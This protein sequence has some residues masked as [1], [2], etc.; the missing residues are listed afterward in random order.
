[1]LEAVIVV[2]IITV[3]FAA[4]LSTAAYFLRG[5]LRAADSV[6]TAFLLEEGVEAVRFLRDNGYATYITPLVATTTT[7]YLERTSTGWR[8]SS[9]PSLV[10]NEY[11]RTIALARVYRRNSDDD[12][13]PA[14]S[15]DPKTIDTHTTRLTVTVGNTEGSTS[16]ST[17][18]ADIYEN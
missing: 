6:Q 15:G 17:Y 2:S 18:V 4:L 5:G 10:L 14:S 9:S 7:L 1:M 3:A 12:I 16:L 11:R 8:A 13:V